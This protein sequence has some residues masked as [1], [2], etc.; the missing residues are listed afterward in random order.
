MR[1]LLL[2]ACLTLTACD[3]GNGLRPLPDK[4]IHM[5]S[6]AAI[7]D[8]LAFACKHETLTPGSADSDVL[9]QYARWLEKNNQLKQ[10][11]STDLEI[12]RLYRIATEN[13][14]PKANINLQNGGLRGKYKLRGHEHLRF[15]QDLIDA[16]V[17]TGYYFVSVF[18]KNGIADLKLDM[19][20]SLRYLRKAADEGSAQAQYEIGDALA[21]SSRAPDV[22]R[23]MRRC[24][25][26]QGHG[27]AALELAVNLQGRRQYR[28]AL[29]AFQLGVAAGDETSAG[30]LDDSFRGPEPTDEL[31]YLALDKDLDRA[32]RYN[33]IW[34]ILADYSY[35]HPKVPEINEIL[36]L[37]PAKLPPWDGKLQWL[38]AREANVPP[39]KPSPEL[40]QRLT[41]D[42][43]LDPATGGPMPGAKGFSQ[44]DL[45][46]GPCVA[47]SKC[48]VSGWWQVHEH[49]ELHTP[50]GQPIVRH[51]EQGEVLPVERMRYY[52]DRI[53]PLPK[54]Q[55][56]GP[57]RVW[58]TLA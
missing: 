49:S 25:A 17:A 44:A 37:P 26:E 33:K 27:D 2:L 22:A 53:W 47:G 43:K 6:L 42:L 10:D 30:W 15:S 23:Q 3:D 36:P 28:D 14:H 16:N 21:P 56:E 57:V 18:L 4:D 8:N 9:F 31:H 20:M 55:H 58:W 39:E 38:E 1:R 29:E 54:S 12:S 48:P 45:S 40:I 41:R 32:D 51:F 5:K 50:N 52:R 13:G 34:N 24:A 46:A 19:E 35:A 11:P 7:K